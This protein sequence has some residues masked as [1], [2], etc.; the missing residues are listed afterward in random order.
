VFNMVKSKPNHSRTIRIGCAGWSLPK[1]HADLFP[2][3]GSHLERYASQFPTVEINS[4]Y[5]KPH[6]PTTYARWAKSVSADFQFSVKVPKAITHE[7]RLVNANDL[8][9]SFLA[10]VTQLGDK[11]GALL[12]QLPPS[13]SFA[14]AIAESFFAVLRDRFDGNVALEPRHPTWFETDV[15][16]LIR[17]YRVARVAADPAVVPTAAGPGG[18][19]GLVYYRLHGSPKIYYSAYQDEQLAALAES[20]R[21]AAKS[22]A[23]WCIFDNTAAGAATLNALDVLERIES[24]PAS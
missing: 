9:D 5:D 4:S 13:L 16:R 1:E 14:V 22:G 7:H 11:L 19:D 18:W 12:V 20:L 8:L 10:E 3:E 21:L 23:V 17:R 6:R 24:E 2:A 15:D